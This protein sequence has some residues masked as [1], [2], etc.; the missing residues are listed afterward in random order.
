MGNRGES[1]QPIS[2]E[3]RGK[4]QRHQHHQQ[5]VNGYAISPG[6]GAIV[7]HNKIT[8]TG[9]GVHLT[10]EGTQFYNNYIDTKGHQHL[11]DL[12]ARTRPF[13]HRMIELHGVK[14]EGKNTKNCKIYNNFVRITQHQPVD[15]D[16]KGDP[17]DKMDNGVYLRS[18]ASSIEKGKL[19]DLKQNWE[20]DRWRFYYVK[21]DPNKPPVKIT[22][23]DATTLYSDFDAKA[24]SEYTIYMKWTYVPP[25]PLTIACYDPNGMNE[26]Y[27]NTF[28]G[29]TTYEKNRHGEYGDSG[30]WGTS[31]MFVMMN[32][33]P[34]EPGK[35][36][37]SIYD[38][39]FFSNDLFINSYTDI[40]M[41]IKVRNNTFT[42]LKEPFTTERDNRIRNVGTVYEEQVRNSNNIFNE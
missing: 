8:S 32:K 27:G 15:S 17:K 2:G 5:Y 37:A 24:S 30:E 20:K 9:R 12:P 6:S 13:H 39:Q 10:G 41:D 36:S 19:V 35:Y 38:N 31:I 42:L 11:S 4:L 28:I 23:N 21:Y 18:N 14:F 16:G 33:G 40:N 34:A 3:C 1:A 22:G 25:T 26:I 29:I 7:H